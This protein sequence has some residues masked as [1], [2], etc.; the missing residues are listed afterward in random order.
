MLS[1]SGISSRV[2]GVWPQSGEGKGAGDLAV[3][4]TDEA[5]WMCAE[6]TLTRLHGGMLTLRDRRL[7]AETHHQR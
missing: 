1:S 2:G 5:L 6:G 7:G 4:R 3:H